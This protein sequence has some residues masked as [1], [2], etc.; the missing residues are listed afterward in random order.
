MKWVCVLL[1]ELLCGLYVCI[2]IAIVW[3]IEGVNAPTWYNTTYYY[4]NS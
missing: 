2:V 1:H 4:A 3:K